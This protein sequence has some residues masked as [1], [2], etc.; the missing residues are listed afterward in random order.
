MNNQICVLFIAGWFDRLE[1]RIGYM[2][3]YDKALSS[4]RR[5]VKVQ[6]IPASCWG[7]V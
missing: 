1:Q 6:I 7:K 4:E 5:A 3:R 2:A